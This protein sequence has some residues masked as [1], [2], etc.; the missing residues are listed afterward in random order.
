MVLP[1]TNAVYAQLI[2]GKP[3]FIFSQACANPGFNSFEVQINF[4]ASP[5][6]DPANQF[7]VELSSADGDFSS[8]TVI[9]TTA[10][11]ELNAPGKVKVAIPTNASGEKYQIRVKSTTA[12]LPLSPQKSIVFPAYYKQHDTQFTINNAIPNATFCAGGSYILSVDPNGN[13]VTNSPLQ[14]PSLTYNWFK[15]NGPLLPETPVATASSSS[16]TVTSPGSYFVKT[17]Y[18]A[19][20]SDSDSYSNIVEVFQ[21][22]TSAS[23]SITSSKGN[24]FCP[25]EGATTLTAVAGNSYQW[26]KDGVKID[27]ATAINYQATVAGKYDVKVDFGGCQATATIELQGE[28]INSS[29]DVPDDNVI[30]VGDKLTVT[31]TTDASSPTFQW[32]LNNNPIAGA[33]T[34]VYEVSS[35]GNYKIIISQAGSC[36]IN[37]ELPFT[38]RLTSDPFPDVTDIPNVIILSSVYKN[39]KEWFFQLPEPELKT[40][41]EVLNKGVGVIIISANGDIVYQTDDYSYNWPNVNLDMWPLSN[42][43]FKN[44]NPVYYYI[45][46]TKDNKMIKGS[47]TVIK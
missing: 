30:E 32:Y 41:P 12:S 20:T 31:A 5:S 25:S 9:Y 17:N 16:Y 23:A 7:I 27:G 4:S 1:L 21:S 45:I 46:T 13:G 38:V 11:G 43:D 3:T 26:F 18:G 24:P 39:N 19:C 35:K 47:I 22:A 34:N 44:I 15:Y 10:V 40:P 42:I 8:P 6:L 28:A 29:I 2:I 14:F 36:N 37:Q 33:T